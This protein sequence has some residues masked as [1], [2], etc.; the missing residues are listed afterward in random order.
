MYSVTTLLFWWQISCRNCDRVTHNCKPQ[1]VLRD[2]FASFKNKLLYVIET[3]TVSW[4]TYVILSQFGCLKIVENHKLSQPNDLLC[5][6]V[7]ATCFTA[8]NHVS[9]LLKNLF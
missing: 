8:V 6:T 5:L 3:G 9:L 2:K 1:Y 4:K 7:D